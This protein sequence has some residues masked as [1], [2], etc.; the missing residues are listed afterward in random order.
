MS[1]APQPAQRQTPPWRSNP[2]QPTHPAS[3]PTHRPPAQPPTRPPAQPPAA[4]PPI[5][6]PAYTPHTAPANPAGAIHPDLAALLTEYDNLVDSF[7]KGFIAEQDALSL[8]AALVVVDA[9]GA[10][11]S[12]DE[13]RNFTSRPTPDAPAR[14]TDPAHFALHHAPQTQHATQ[15]YNTPVEHAPSPRSYRQRPALPKHLGSLTDLLTRNK[16]TAAVA[17]LSVLVVVAAF[18]ARSSSSTDSD[19]PPVS[20]PVSTPDTSQAPTSAYAQG[21]LTTL[22][23]PDPA[24]ITP[25]FAQPL[26]GSESTLEHARFIGLAALEAQLV[27]AEASGDTNAA[28][29]PFIVQDAAGVQIAAGTLSWVA[30]DGKWLLASWPALTPS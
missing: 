6:P 14:I 22:T 11:W 28:S 8:L 21:V 15:G 23:S 4:R 13:H 9:S 17:A 3:A 24:A 30:Q 7:E 26:A 25:L 10:H 1:H 16:L 20:A 29:Q 12:L 5:H 19:T 18:V 27:P 2:Q